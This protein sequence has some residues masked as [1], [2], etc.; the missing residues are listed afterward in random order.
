MPSKW[1][2]KKCF[3]YLSIGDHGNIQYIIEKSYFI[4]LDFF[5]IY[6]SGNLYFCEII[7]VFKNTLKVFKIALSNK[8]MIINIDPFFSGI[9]NVNCFIS[10]NMTLMGFP[11]PS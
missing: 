4:N 10:L 11:L 9:F 7:S 6:L 5:N 2:V 8:G 1:P 3:Y